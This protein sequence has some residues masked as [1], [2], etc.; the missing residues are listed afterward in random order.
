MSVYPSATVASF[1][2]LTPVLSVLLG[3]ALMG[4]SLSLAI[5]GAV[6]LVAAGIVLIN[7]APRRQVATDG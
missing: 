7:R 3:W 1:S 6:G 5:L 4:E 2:F